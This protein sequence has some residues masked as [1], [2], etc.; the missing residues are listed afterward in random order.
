MRTTP[1][2]HTSLEVTGETVVTQQK[3]STDRSAHGETFSDQTISF[4]VITPQML[5]PSIYKN[6]HPARD[7]CLSLYSSREALIA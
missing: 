5:C 2:M 3:I 7:K 4:H 1:T 6:V